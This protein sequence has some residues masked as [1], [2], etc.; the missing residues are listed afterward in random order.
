[1]D[2]KT[3]VD[4]GTKALNAHDIERFAALHDD[5]AEIVQSGVPGRR[6]ADA[7]AS[8]KALMDGVPDLSFTIDDIVIQGDKAFFEGTFTGTQ[9]KPLRLPGGP[10]IPA[11]GKRFSVPQAAHLTMRNDKA[12]KVH[13]FND[14]ME[15]MEQLGLMPQP[16][17]ARG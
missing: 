15:L 4:E 8:L 2:V 16:Q 11:T 10:E 9:S 1:M 13:V 6:K 5:N 14:R 3:L 7:I 12:V 17:S